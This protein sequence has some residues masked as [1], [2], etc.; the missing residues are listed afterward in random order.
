MQFQIL[1]KYHTTIETKQRRRYI[2]IKNDDGVRFFSE[3]EIRNY[4]QQ[5]YKQL[6]SKHSLPTYKKQ[7]SNYRENKTQIYQEIRLNKIDE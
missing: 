4:T 7:W 2:C 3:G 6:Y 5:H 1:L